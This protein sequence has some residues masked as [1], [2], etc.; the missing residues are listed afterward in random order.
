MA[1]LAMPADRRSTPAQQ[2][3]DRFATIYATHRERITALVLRE[4][5]GNDH[6]LAEDL[7][8]TTFFHA[9]LDLHKCKATTDAQTFAW[10]ATMARRTVMQHYRVARNT[11]EIPADTGHW[12]YAN[13]AFVPAAGGALAPLRG[14]YEGDS[15]PNMDEALRRLRQSRQL[16]GAR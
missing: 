14:G 12:A 3:N 7:A 2:L 6:H 1:D 10:L 11:R 4:V 5:R 9:W 16:A 8:A 13:R 15:D